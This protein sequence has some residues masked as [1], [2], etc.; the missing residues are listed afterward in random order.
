MAL[1]GRPN[2]GKSAL[3]NA[4]I[5][6]KLSIVTARAQT[7]R[8]QVLGILTTDCAQVV[9]VDT[10]GLLVP[11]YRLQESMLRTALAAIKD[12]DLILLLL[13]AGRPDEVPSPDLVPQL[14]LRR[15][16][17]TCAINKIDLPAPG[18]IARLQAWAESALGLEPML[19]SALTGDGLAGL[20]DQLIGQL[21]PSPFLY[22]A[23]DL[24][25]QPTRF[26]VQELVR[27]TIFEQYEQELPYSTVTRVEEFREGRAPI[28]IRVTVY[29]ERASQKAIL[30]GKDGRAIREL[31]RSARQKI[32]KL[33]G[34]EVYLDLWV[35]TL[36]GWR[37][38]SATL[39]FLGYAVPP[40]S[41]GR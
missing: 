8:E 41:T 35:K 10:P 23:D 28:Y 27:E 18:G 40:E 9:F 15:K 19:C 16:D 13:D 32:E 4:L 14:S 36:P 34:A 25:V 22:P 3:L 39:K 26:F 5:G 24:A 11:K 7:T 37:N 20:Q 30:L 17:L 31:G 12:A 1:V 38:K 2:V 33:V 21:P 6:E 29:V